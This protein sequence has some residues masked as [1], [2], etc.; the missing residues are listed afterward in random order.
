MMKIC[1]LCKSL[2]FKSFK[3]NLTECKKCGLVVDEFIWVDNANKIMNEEHFGES[4][5]SRERTFWD[6]F[7]ESIKNKKI[8][9]RLKLTKK[10]REKILEI[11]V[12][13]GSF[14]NE[15]KKS[16]HIVTGCDLSEEI[17]ASVTK[18]Y[19]IEMFC[20]SPKDLSQKET[21]GI[22]ILNHV[23]EHV[24]DPVD[25]LR[26]VRELLRPDGRIH[27]AVPNIRCFEAI[28]SGWGSY[29]PYH[30]SYFSTST[31]EKTVRR[32]GISPEYII[33]NDTFSGWYIAIFR[34]LTKSY[35]RSHANSSTSINIR[36]TES[37]YVHMYRLLMAISGL[38]SYPLRFIQGKLGFGDEIVCV[39]RSSESHNVLHS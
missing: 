14:L 31:L 32:A 24:R 34:T 28:L 2:D 27:I 26:S 25:F 33:T 23:L 11:G 39:A 3:F 29:E 16:G 20:C 36:N 38:V 37:I 10:R 12:G 19:G 8:I 30:L 4:I 18:N 6:V 35:Y 15:A 21:Y 17:C 7:F 1:P 22:I 5:E 9:N 13:S